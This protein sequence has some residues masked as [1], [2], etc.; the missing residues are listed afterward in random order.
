LLLEYFCSLAT[1]LNCLYLISVCS[2]VCVYVCMYV[3]MC[4]YVYVCTYEYMYVCMYVCIHVLCMCVFFLIY[5]H[6]LL[7]MLHY[8]MVILHAIFLHVVQTIC[9][10]VAL[11]VQFVTVYV[12]L[13][14]TMLFVKVLSVCH[15]CCY[16]RSTFLS[17]CLSDLWLFCIEHDT[18][19]KEFE[20]FIVSDPCVFA[21]SSVQIYSLVLGHV[22]CFRRFVSTFRKQNATANCGV[23]G[24][25]VSA[26]SGATI[27]WKCSSYRPPIHVWSILI[28][29]THLRLRLTSGHFT[30]RFY[31]KT[32]YTFAF[33]PT[34]TTCPAHLILSDLVTWNLLHVALRVNVFEMGF[35]PCGLWYLSDM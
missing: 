28:S 35:W 19:C 15:A 17:Y 13:F 3:C 12:S 23:E 5:I 32:V 21:C 31:T 4:M 7:S 24:D 26:H 25:S 11:F 8:I 33:S 29:S 1:F 30:S 9:N 20:M 22:L 14:I 10:T 18:V 2:Y 6:L 16:I 27:V 34:R